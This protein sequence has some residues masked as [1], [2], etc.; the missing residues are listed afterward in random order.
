MEWVYV[1]ERLPDI[2]KE[3]LVAI[4]QFPDMG[5]DG[6]TYLLA[7]FIDEGFLSFENSKIIDNVTYWMPLPEPPK[8]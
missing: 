6:Y 4:L 7:T 1:K 3:C 2:S 8:E 5:N